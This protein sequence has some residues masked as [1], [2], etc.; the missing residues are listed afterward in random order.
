LEIDAV[1]SDPPDPSLNVGLSTQVSLQY[2]QDTDVSSVQDFEVPGPHSPAPLVDRPGFNSQ[3]SLQ[4]VRDTDVSSVQDFDVPEEILFVHSESDSDEELQ[5]GSEQEWESDTANENKSYKEL[6]SDLAQKWLV[7][8]LTHNVSKTASNE[9]WAL[10]KQCFSDLFAAKVAEGVRKRV[11]SFKY[12]R[13]KMQDDN[14][15]DIEMEIGYTDK[16][17]GEITIV[18]DLKK[19]PLSKFPAHLFAKTHEKCS[20]KV[21]TRRTY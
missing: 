15:P 14:L 7:T 11:P 10:A 8:E 18:T 16:A 9:F 4:Y 21:K 1:Q 3:L 13:R 19:T 17:T 20:I 2:V 12:L 5:S 6:L